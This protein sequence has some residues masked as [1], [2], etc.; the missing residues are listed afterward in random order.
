MPRAKPKAPK[1]KKK[2]SP[3]VAAATMVPL[4]IGLAMNATPS[5]RRHSTPAGPGAFVPACTLPFNDIKMHHPIDDS[6]GPDGKVSTQAEAQQN[7]AKNN[8]CAAGAPVNI[9]FEV[10]HQ[11]Q[12]DAEDKNISFGS[13][14]QIPDDR[15]PLL[16]LPTKAGAIG[17]GTAVR[18]V[19]FVIDAHF[20]NVGKGK[21]ETV[22]CKLTHRDENDIHIVLG[23][24]SNHDDECSSATAEMS[25]HFRPDVWDPSILKNNNEHLYRFTGHLFFDASHKP[26][27]GGKGSP[28]RSTI[29]E[30][31]PVYA[32]DICMDPGNNCRVDSEENWVPLSER[33]GLEGSSETSL[34]LPEEM[35]S[36]PILDRTLHPRAASSGPSPTG[37]P[38]ALMAR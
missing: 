32:V 1:K 27:S 13:D 3:L 15:R 8:F 22:N 38:L 34:R 23:E 30:I 28:K 20:S 19:A 14:R 2:K 31:H 9:D 36:E 35:P 37:D 10:L 6:C 21:G 7:D 16:Q 18:L 17:E 11:L 29:W 33:V 4:A 25:P 24:N 26:C 12:K 5:A